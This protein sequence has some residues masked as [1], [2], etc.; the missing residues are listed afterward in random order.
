MLLEGLR[1][2]T[3][4]GSSE[5][6]ERKGGEGRGESRIGK[7]LYECKVSVRDHERSNVDQVVVDLVD[8]SDQ[9]VL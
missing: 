1:C 6:L 8:Y 7:S 9:K 2:N 3:R 5:V 4:I